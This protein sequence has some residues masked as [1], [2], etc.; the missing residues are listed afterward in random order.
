VTAI[1]G[2]RRNATIAAFV[3]GVVGIGAVGGLGYA[4]VDN[5]ANSRA[6]RLVTTVAPD[7][8]MQH[9]PDTATALVA[10]SDEDGWLTSVAVLALDP[11][12]VGGSI[13]S[14]S[15]SGDSASGNTSALAPLNAVYVVD[16]PDELLGAI[17]GLTGMSFDVAEVLDAERFAALATPL[18]ELTVELPTE[19]RDA[20]T[21][22]RYAAGVVQMTPDEAGAAIVSRD[23][24]IDDPLLD[25][26]R[27]AVWAAI[28]DRVG[29]G[30]GAGVTGGA[31]DATPTTLDEFVARLFAG[32]VE[33][34]SFTYKPIAATRVAEQLADE[35]VAAF[36]EHG[37]ANVT[38]VAHDR[39]ELLMVLGA[40]APARLGAPFEGPTVRVLARFA[41]ADLEPL[42]YNNADVARQAINRLLFAKVNVMS[43]GQVDTAP[44]VTLIEVASE[45]EL[46][47]AEESYGTLFGES[48]VRVAEA[49]IDGID[50]QITL[51]RAYLGT[52]EPAE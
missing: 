8:P 9:L 50:M 31:E 48:E 45:P 37:D 44:E 23:P 30:I 47:D 20:S 12:G 25:P 36:A 7:Q 22:Q 33:H 28:A 19:L 3:A 42:G 16:G 27:A 14:L 5:L 39:A 40:I 51:G 38:V 49:L 26:A 10:T 2:R 21:G 24:T 46:A 52:V 32:R 41:P 1:R 17:E 18:G 43:F 34:R 13:V 11:S 6:G 4:G 35:Y 15:P 29:S